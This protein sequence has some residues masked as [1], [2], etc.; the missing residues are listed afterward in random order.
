MSDIP[1]KC[2]VWDYCLLRENYKIIFCVWCKKIVA[3][4]KDGKRVESNDYKQTR[5]NKKQ[6]SEETLNDSV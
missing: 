6:Y 5:Y 1:H 2:C 4:E 3:Y